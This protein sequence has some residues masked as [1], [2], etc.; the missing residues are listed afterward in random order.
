MNQMKTVIS[1]VLRRTKIETMGSREDIEVSMELV[2]KL[3]SAPN[4]KFY[5]I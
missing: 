3:E 4:V 1:T 5:K 2:L